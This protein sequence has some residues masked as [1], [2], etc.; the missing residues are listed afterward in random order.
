[1]R[2]SS[3]S[4]PAR[5][6][7]SRSGQAHERRLRVKPLHI[8]VALGASA[9]AAGQL[10]AAA[11]RGTAD[12]TAAL[13]FTPRG[14]VLLQQLPHQ[15]AAAPP[16]LAPAVLLVYA[17]RYVVDVRV[18]VRWRQPPQA[19]LSQQQQRQ[20]QQRQRRHCR[21]SCWKARDGVC[22]E[23][24]PHR[25]PAMQEQQEQQ[26]RAQGLPAGVSAV[27]CDLGTD[28]D[29]CGAWYGQQADNT[30]C[31]RSHTA[32]GHVGARCRPA[33]C[34]SQLC[35]KQCACCT[36]QESTG[37]CTHTH[38]RAHAHAHTQA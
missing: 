25:L 12:A 20:Q 37:A 21:N 1:M 30:W 26:Q 17:L 31:A 13:N 22:D 7:G 36:G 4:L 15:L 34:S 2:S 9:A 35:S 33:V 19:A 28:C 18:S 24:R 14:A 10:L 5:A 27:H 23:G 6:T 16:L 8:G 38:T 32:Q 3:S 29:D 11:A